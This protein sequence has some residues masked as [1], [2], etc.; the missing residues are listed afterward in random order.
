MKKYNLLNESLKAVYEKAINLLILKGQAGFGKTYTTLKYAK[1]NNVNYEYVNN[2]AT[3][4]ALYKLLYLKRN[5]SLIIFD[6]LQSITDPKIKAMFKAIC[7]ESEGGKRTISYHS[8]SKILEENKLPESFEFNPGIVLIFNKIVPDFESI[9]NRGITINFEFNF[10]EKLEILEYFKDSA[11]ID[12][13]VLKYVKDNCSEATEN[14]SIRSLVILSNL[15][16]KGF[17]FKLFADEVLRN[18]DDVSELINCDEKDW[19]NK[20]GMHR[21]SYYRKKKRFGLE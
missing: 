17:D 16:G 13:E 14:L 15:K 7:W 6:D 3:P 4:L 10:E 5:K 20:T 18:N 9:V 8:T 12:D 1:D 11:K 21:S 19:C 2:Y